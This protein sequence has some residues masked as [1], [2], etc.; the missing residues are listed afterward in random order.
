MYGHAV[1]QGNAA[2]FINHCCDPNCVAR[3]IEV[4]GQKKIAIHTL[5]RIEVGE[6]LAYDYKV[7]SGSGILSGGGKQSTSKVAVTRRHVDV[8]LPR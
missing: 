2:R 4:G 3:I 7:S 8:T 6:E 1:P 5:R